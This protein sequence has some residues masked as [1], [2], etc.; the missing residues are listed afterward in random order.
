GHGKGR[1]GR[2]ANIGEFARDLSLEHP[3]C[4]FQVMKRHFARYTPEMVERTCGVPRDLFLSVAQTYTAA[5]GR[6][7]TGAICYAVG[8]TQHSVGVQIIR[9][10]AILQLLLGNVGRPGG[11]I[12]ALR[13]HASIQG[14][15][16]IPTLYD[17][18]PGYLPMPVF[19]EDIGSLDD[20][21]RAHSSRSGWWANFDKYSVSLLK[22][23][24]GEAA[25]AENEFGFAWLPRLTGDHSHLSY[26]LDM[27]DGGI[28]GLFVMGQNP[29][30]GAP[31]S[32][33]ERKALARLKWLVVRD[34]VE[35]ETATFWYDSPEVERG[36]L[37]PEEIGTEVF[38]FPVAGH[39]E[40][41]GTFTNTQR[42]LQW[43]EKAVDPPGDARSEAWFVYHLGRRLKEKARR[44]PR[45][46]NAGLNAL[47]WSYRTETPHDEPAVDDVL[48]EINGRRVA[49]GALVGSFADLRNDGSTSCGCWIYS[50]VYPRDGENRAAKRDAR[51]PYG[52]GWGFAWPLDRRVLYNRASAAPDGTPW[53]ERKKLIW[54]DAAQERWTGH[55][56]PDFRLD[57]RPDQPPDPS[58][59]G[60]AALPGDAP[61]L[62]HEDGLAWLWVPNGLKDGPLPTHYESFES[63]IRNPLYAQHDNPAADRRERPDNQYASSP[64][65]RFP[66]V[67]TTYRLTEHHTAGGMSRTLSHLAELQPELFCEISPELADETGIRHHDWATIVTPRGIVEARAL[68]TSRIPPLRLGDRVVHQVGLP[69][70]WGSRGLVRGDAVNDLLSISQEPNVRIMESKALLCGVRPGRRP[71]GAAALAEMDLLMRQSV[72]VDDPHS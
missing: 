46:R 1:T 40:K 22:A 37:R 63:P 50:G 58:A 49:D 51:G 53:S 13:G 35:I 68:V 55:D 4:V 9:A 54:W 34:L 31:H 29:A 62:L 8:W 21:N 7:R 19:R 28:E 24:Y 27:A 48:R 43:R 25:T 32:R 38:L 6:D 17:V 15:T 39:A 14:S 72:R 3:R 60:D 36:E 33:L 20:Y 67:L 11:G 26:W 16:D 2:A 57:K 66:Y 41:A 12:L 5:S 69:Y 52:A 71:R 42:L 10:A 70:H 61:F 56:V 44:D 64:D 65:V 18:L 45:P 47:T 23:Y 59:S 30:V